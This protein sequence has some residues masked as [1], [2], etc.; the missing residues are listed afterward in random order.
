MSG[1]KPLSQPAYHVGWI[2][3]TIALTTMLAPLNS[4]MIGVA[5]PL[6]TAEFSV[7]LDESG[8][9]VIAYLIVMASLQ[10]VAGKLG[11]RFGHRWMILGGLLYFAFASIG[12]AL[13]PSL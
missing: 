6:V 2:L 4:T 7:G 10:P 12:A 11:D 5:L 1:E 8:W 13:A 3:T 9:L